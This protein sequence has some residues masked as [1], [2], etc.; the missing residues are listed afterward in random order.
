MTQPT[1]PTRTPTPAPAAAPPAD[2]VAGEEDPGA[3]V[4]APAPPPHFFNS[5]DKGAER[6]PPGDEDNRGIAPDRR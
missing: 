5:E 4:D 1:P 3:A 6:S 2:S